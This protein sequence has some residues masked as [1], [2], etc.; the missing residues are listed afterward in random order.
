MHRKMINVLSI[1]QPWA[2]LIVNGYKDIENREWPTNFRGELYIHASKRFDYRGATF[3]DLNYPDIK[4]K[5]PHYP[6]EYIKG[7]IIGR[8]I[9]TDCAIEHNSRWFHGR[10]GFVLNNPETIQPIEVPGRLMIFQIEI[11]P[12]KIISH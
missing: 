2:H 10:Y 5:I 3:I 9:L 11:D 4:R 8:A 7:H 6:F 1:R 12:K